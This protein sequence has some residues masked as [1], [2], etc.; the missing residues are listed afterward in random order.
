MICG[1]TLSFHINGLDTVAFSVRMLS[2][3]AAL[4]QNTQRNREPWLAL[5]LSW[6]VPGGGQFYVKSYA[7]GTIFIILAILFYIFWLASL[8]STKCSIFA[9]TAIRLCSFII[10]R[11][12][13]CVDAYKLAKR[14][15]TGEFEAARTE[16]KDPWLAVF[17]SLLLP[18]LGHGYTRQWVPFGLYFLVF[19][20]LKMLSNRIGYVVAGLLLFR[21]FVC[22]HAYI[23]TTIGRTPGKK[24][25]TAFA[26]FL[27]SI[28]CFKS[29]LLPWLT[30]A[31]LGGTVSAT[32]GP[33]MEPTI[34]T[35]DK[36]VINK[37]MYTKHDPKVGDIIV[38]KIPKYVEI[39]KNVPKRTAYMLCKRVVAV[40]GESVQV[41]GDKV[42][43][44]GEERRFK[45]SEDASENFSY[46]E[47][48]SG[49]NKVWEPYVIFGVTEPYRVPEG[50]YFV[51]GD[52]IQNSMDSRYCGAFP[53]DKIIG[54]VVKIYWPLR[55]IGTLY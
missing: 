15:N 37:L 29:I 2:M 11:V 34:R 18:G 6:L 46:D 22:I 28:G 39:P 27:I 45:I 36:L 35:S 43:V 51:L 4:D 12:F 33:S 42:Y 1:P 30:G 20:V 7:R 55:R 23:S 26:I 21:V 44:N 48:A 32:W 47:I 5:S 8:I 14:F 25:I 53:K 9:S 54:K 13:A 10:V 19:C 17:L 49:G 52:N 3:F 38:L 41:K 31:Y 16:S 40:G 50:C 24:A